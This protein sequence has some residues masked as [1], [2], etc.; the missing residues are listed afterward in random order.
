MLTIFD[1]NRYP[2][3]MTLSAKDGKVVGTWASQGM[4]M[5]MTDLKFADGTL[6][7]K[8]NMGRGPSMAFE[9][10]ITGDSVVGTYTTG[11]GKMESTG[12]RTK[13]APDTAPNGS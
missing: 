4:D 6:H 11:F 9:G 12:K 3:T 1:G 5:V 8:R 7:F 13:R 10:K 2:A